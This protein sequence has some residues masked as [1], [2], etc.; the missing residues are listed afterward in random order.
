MALED[1]RKYRIFQIEDRREL[2]C[3]AED[4]VRVMTSPNF[5]TQQAI[6]VMLRMRPD[7]PVVG[8]VREGG[9]A[10]ALA[11]AANTGHPGSLSTIHCDSAHEAYDRMAEII[12]EVSVSVPHRLIRRTLGLVIHIARIGKKYV[13]TELRVPL[14]YDKEKEE[15]ITKVVADENDLIDN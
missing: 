2:Q 3:D 15:F 10:L 7:R 13:V 8:E 9:P 5:T 1:F 14:G 4:I 11:K 6:V 12:S